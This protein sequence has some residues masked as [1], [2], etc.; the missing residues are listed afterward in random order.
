MANGSEL[1]VRLNKQEPFTVLLNNPGGARYFQNGKFF[2]VG[3]R[4]IKA[5]VEEDSLPAPV[6]S[7]MSR[8]PEVENKTEEKGV[9]YECTKCGK[10]YRDKNWY[11]R[12]MATHEA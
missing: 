9:L 3:G 5:S 6:R 12:H 7:A 10:T 1:S 8:K 2:G 4:P 11:D